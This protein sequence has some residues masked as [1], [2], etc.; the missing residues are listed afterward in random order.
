MILLQLT[1]ET[2]WPLLRFI[3][4]PALQTGD[5]ELWQISIPFKEKFV[6]LAHI[7]DIGIK[8]NR[9]SV[10]VKFNPKALRRMRRM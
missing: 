6:R 9:V 1:L 4:H 5:V 3:P 2:N 8:F 7:A 10:P